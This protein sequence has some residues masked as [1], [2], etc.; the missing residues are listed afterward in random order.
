MNNTDSNQ[1]NN[2]WYRCPICYLVPFIEVS[3]KGNKLFMS[4]KCINDHIYFGPFDEIEKMIKSNSNN[5]CIICEN[6]KKEKNLKLTK[7]NYY[8]SYCFNFFCFNHGEKHN[9]KEKHNVIKIEKNLNSICFEHNKNKIVG[10]CSNHNKNYCKFCKHYK[11]IKKNTNF[12]LKDEVIKKY[13]NEIEKNEKII[14]DINLLF[15]NY[16]K[17]IKELENNFDIYK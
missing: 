4:S 9:L 7:F 6:E 12:I 5:Y 16:K 2:Q 17:L 14:K 13:E 8:C 15:Y 10:Y 3:E 1:F 11:E